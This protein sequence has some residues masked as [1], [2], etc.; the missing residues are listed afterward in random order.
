[1]RGDDCAVFVVSSHKDNLVCV[2]VVHMMSKQ[3][4]QNVCL[5]VFLFL[6]NITE[7]VLFKMVLYIYMC[8][9]VC[10]C[11]CVGGGGCTL[12]FVALVVFFV[13]DVWKEDIHMFM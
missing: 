5:L 12:C 2:L 6:S 4:L 3:I 8:V 13:C 7:L 10:V 1:M 11:V 9:C